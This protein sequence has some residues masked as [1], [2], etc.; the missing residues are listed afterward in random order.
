MALAGFSGPMGRAIRE[1]SGITLFMVMA[2]TNGRMAAFMKDSGE[3]IKWKGLEDLC[4]LTAVC[5]RATM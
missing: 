2:F 3:I 4:G 5:M 1:N